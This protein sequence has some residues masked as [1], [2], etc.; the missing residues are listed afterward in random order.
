MGVDIVW[1][2]GETSAGVGSLPGGKQG[3]ARWVE[4]G[5]EACFKAGMVCVDCGELP[6]VSECTKVLHFIFL[7][8]KRAAFGP[9]SLPELE[10]EVRMPKKQPLFGCDLG[11]KLRSYA[12]STFYIFYFAAI[13]SRGTVLQARHWHCVYSAPVAKCAKSKTQSPK[14][15]SATS[16]DNVHC[17]KYIFF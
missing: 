14:A 2:C 12:T 3:L 11:Q 16:K 6:M 15:K 5:L 9:A 13:G 10:A 8:P 1:D 17:G 4:A 7:R